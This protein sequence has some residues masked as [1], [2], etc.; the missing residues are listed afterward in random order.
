MFRARKRNPNPNFL[1]RIS[2]GGS[3][4]L[5]REGV[6]AE[7]FGMSFATQGNPIFWRDPRIFARIS[8]GC[9]KSLRK[10]CVHFSFPNV[11]WAHIPQ[12]APKHVFQLKMWKLFGWHALML[13]VDIDMGIVIAQRFVYI[14]H[15]NFM[16]LVVRCWNIHH[17]SWQTLCAPLCD[18]RV[19]ICGPQLQGK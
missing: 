5:P 10:N 1:V 11:N 15:I 3:G 17:R 14:I 16:W 6:G 12:D 2:S 9:P 7:K 13:K 18:V 8:R 19:M 4:G